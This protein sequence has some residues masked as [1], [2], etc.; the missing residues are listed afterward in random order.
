MGKLTVLKINN[1]KIAATVSSCCAAC[2]FSNI[3]GQDVVIYETQL[4]L[5]LLWLLVI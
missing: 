3:L 5:P 2:D 1:T 4:N